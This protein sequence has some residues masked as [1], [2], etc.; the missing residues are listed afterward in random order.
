MIPFYSKIEQTKNKQKNKQL[1]KK[2]QTKNLCIK[3]FLLS[4]DTKKP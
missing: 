4:F 1:P 2:P 3:K